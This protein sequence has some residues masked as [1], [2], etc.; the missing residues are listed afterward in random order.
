MLPGRRGERH[1]LRTTRRRGTSRSAGSAPT[2]SRTTPHARAIRSPRSS[3]GSA[4]ASRRRPPVGRLSW[5]SQAPYGRRLVSMRTTLKRGV[6]RGAGPQRQRHAVFPPAPLSAVTRYRQPPTPAALSALG[7]FGR[8][9]LVTLL[10]L[11]DRARASPAAPTSGST[12]RSPTV[13]AHTPDV[14]R[15]REA[16]DVPLAHHAAIALVI[17]YDQRARATEP[18]RRAPTR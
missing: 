11:V 4:R 10:V 16:L 6:G 18:A 14:V 2:S 7:L 13:R 8:I 17:G 12:S 5:P 3:A 1:L 15:A 9:L